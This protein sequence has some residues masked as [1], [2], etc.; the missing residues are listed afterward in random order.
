MT[1]TG[2]E[3]SLKKALAG[4]SAVKNPKTSLLQS[5]AE[6]DLEL[7]FGSVSSVMEHIV[8]TTPFKCEQVT[9]QGTNVDVVV[10]GDPF[11]FINN[12]DEWPS[13]VIDITLVERT[14]VNI[15]YDADLVGARDLV[16][17]G[18]NRTLHLAPPRGDATVDK[19][20]KHVR[21]IGLM[22]L[23]SAILTIPV[24]VLAWAPLPER[25]VAYGSASLALATLVQFLIAG[26]FYPKA[27]KALIFSKMIEMDLLIVLSTTAAYVFS[28]VSFGY[29]VAGQPLSTGQFFETSTLLVTLIMVGRYVAAMARQKA[30]ESISIRSL[31]PQTA[32]I[33]EET[34]ERE[35]D[36]R[37]LQYSDTFKVLPHCKIPTDGTVVSG[38]SEVDESM[39]TGESRPVEKYFKNHVIA[40]SING[41]GT[42][43]VRLARLPGQKH[44]LHHRGYGRRGG[45]FEAQAAGSC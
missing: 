8:R 42:L 30:V 2:C 9:D 32:I 43:L 28:V 45:V 25:E 20:N 39:V 6:F 3:T 36:A 41:S 12:H 23:L 33:V 26:P 7:S 4:L 19:S 17:K 22:T 15:V 29:L 11:E 27:L 13:G 1:C 35:I 18:W 21:K 5:K 44:Y 24:L 31:Q 10:L 14:I 37:L 34:G 40:G 38:S 16:E